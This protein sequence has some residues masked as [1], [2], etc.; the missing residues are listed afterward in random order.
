[1]KKLMKKRY[2]TC[3]GDAY[4]KMAFSKYCRDCG[5]YHDE[6]TKKIRTISARIKHANSIITL[7]NV[8]ITHIR[9]R[10][11]NEIKDPDIK[12]Y[13]RCKYCKRRIE[14]DEKTYGGKC[15][16]CLISEIVR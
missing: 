1:M 16:K 9:Y 6:I 11:L 12:R 15:L 4:Y 3:C 13:S 7:S 10:L 5:I 8:K 2:C 14:K